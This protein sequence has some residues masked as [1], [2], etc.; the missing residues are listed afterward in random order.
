VLR[1]F[2]PVLLAVAVAA[3][4]C[5][6]GDDK[7]DQ[8]KPTAAT[9][10]PPAVQTG[11]PNGSPTPA[12]SLTGGPGANP[13]QTLCKLLTADDFKGA[14]LSTATAP[15][16]TNVTDVEAFCIY[17][18][19]IELDV[20]LSKTASDATG[21]YE[22]TVATAGTATATN[23]VSGA[24]ASAYGSNASR[25]L[26]GVVVRKGR[27]VYLLSV[28]SGTANAKNAC[29]NLATIALGRSAGLT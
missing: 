14:G 21:V 18:K 6:S 15:D 28:P 2:F 8:A 22:N 25:G 29:I 13:N 19:D 27:L 4:G 3:A 5:T 16:T 17:G 9:S 11:G 7:K 10:T 20:F 23:V 1:R 24:D 12:T 26:V